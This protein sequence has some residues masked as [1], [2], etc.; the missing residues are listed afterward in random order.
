MMGLNDPGWLVLY[1]IVTHPSRA[2]I[3]FDPPLPDS[4]Y[5]D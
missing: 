2:K 3:R 4:I 1:P 5:F